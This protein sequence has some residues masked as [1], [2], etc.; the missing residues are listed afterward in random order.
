MSMILTGRI[1][2][3]RCGA[4]VAASLEIKGVDHQPGYLRLT[5]AYASQNVNHTCQGTDPNT[6]PPPPPA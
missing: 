6:I 5:P 2:C 1:Y 4:E 3:P